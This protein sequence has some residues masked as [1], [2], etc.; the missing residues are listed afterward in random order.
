MVHTEEDGNE[1]SSC[2]V[3]IGL[4]SGIIVHELMKRKDVLAE[5]R[6]GGEEQNFGRIPED[7]SV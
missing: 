5:R 7:T 4:S 3:T 6:D 2:R 1:A